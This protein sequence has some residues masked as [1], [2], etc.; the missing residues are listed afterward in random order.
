MPNIDSYSPG[1][2]CWIELSTTDQPAAKQFYMSLFG[3][4]A[5]DMPMG[6]DEFYTMFQLDG[7]VAAACCT[8]RP[9]ERAHGAPPNWL[10]YIATADADATVA[11]AA[12]LGGKALMGAFDV[13]DAGRMAVIRDPAGAVFAVWQ[14]NKNHGISIAGVPGT[15]CWADLN[16]RSQEAGAQFYTGLFGWQAAPGEHDT[17]GYLHIKNGDAFIGGIPPL[18]QL[19][20]GAPPHWII[21]FLV[22]D[23]DAV[24]AKAKELGGS[25]HTPPL[26]LE[27]VGTFAVV[28]DPQGA[29]FS[30]FKPA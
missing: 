13:F 3:W 30:I 19:P 11:R 22:S 2:F 29:V 12:E 9:D 8:L 5:N 14:A 17:S 18:S 15:L 23:C 28:A 7:R 6:P 24:A 26:T 20:P 16:T 21:Y 1:S 4:S 25:I 10:L 27:G